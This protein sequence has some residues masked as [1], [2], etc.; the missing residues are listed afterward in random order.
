MSISNW[1][2][3]F[4]D[5]IQLSNTVVE[6]IANRY[7]LITRR[8]NLD[9]Y[10]TDSKTLNS[11]YV[12][13]YG[14]DTDIH[15]SDIDILFQL[16]YW[17]YEQYNTH[18]NNGQSALLQSVKK[19]IEKTYIS[20]MKADGQVIG[21]KFS[22]GIEFELVPAFINDDLSFTYPDS[23]YGGSW[24]IT[25]PKPEIMEIRNKNNLWNKNLKRLARMAKA[26]KDNWNVPMGGLLIDT[27]AYNFLTNWKYNDRSY[28]FYDWMSRDFFKYLSEQND[29]QSYWLSPGA[30]QRVMKKGNFAYKAKQCYNI[31]IQAIEKENYASSAKSKWR[32]IYG[33]KFPK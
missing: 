21:I 10:N 25:N 24:K 32:E 6:T 3:T 31:A 4:N 22:D 20:Y 26:W 17:V 8:L 1:F 12:G 9:Y 18:I 28:S 11:L 2:K 13:S 19:S 30:R 29:Q 33:T 7:K 16:P 15:I 14:R 27:M 5:E 23:N